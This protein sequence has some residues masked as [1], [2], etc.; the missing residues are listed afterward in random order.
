MACIPVATH[1]LINTGESCVV[2]L[3]GK[4]HSLNFHTLNDVDQIP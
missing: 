1:Y 4:T 2:W 3:H